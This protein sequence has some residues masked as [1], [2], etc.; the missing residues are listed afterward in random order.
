MLVLIHFSKS[1]LFFR[2]KHY[3]YFLTWTVTWILTHSHSPVILRALS[4]ELTFLWLP[5]LRSFSC[6]DQSARK[7]QSIY[8]NM[9]MRYFPKIIIIPMSDP[10]AK[11]RPII[12]P[13][14]L[15]AMPIW[16]EPSNKAIC[17]RAIQPFPSLDKRCTF[18]YS[19]RTE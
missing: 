4:Y 14:I 15:K 6:E 12:S 16:T 11:S 17:Y 5:L 13:K 1:W 18:F 2:P 10:K 3:T 7:R 19:N 8:V 9:L